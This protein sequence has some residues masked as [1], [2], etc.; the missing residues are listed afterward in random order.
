MQGI[1]L[2]KYVGIFELF[3]L[4]ISEMINATLTMR[5]TDRQAWVFKKSQNFY[6][7]FQVVQWPDAVPGVPLG[8]PGLHLPQPQPRGPNSLQGSGKTNR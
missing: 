4:M 7:I 5:I 1:L 8:D 6:L 2:F 3:I